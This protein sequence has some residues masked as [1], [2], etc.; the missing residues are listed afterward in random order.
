MLLNSLYF[1]VIFNVNLIPM[2]P[3]YQC[4]ANGW[5]VSV[6]INNSMNYLTFQSV[7][8]P[9]P[10]LENG[11]C[12]Q[13]RLVLSIHLTEGILLLN[14]TRWTS[15]ARKNARF[16]FACTGKYLQVRNKKTIF[17]YKQTNK[18][19]TVQ[20]FSV[21]HVQYCNCP[22]CSFTIGFPQSGE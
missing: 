6:Q 10:A 19:L 21:F 5:H 20:Y 14:F 9:S 11:E 22:S 15:I 18:K 4:T 1:C 13:E 2:D 3:T 8:S 17:Q 12:S 16:S 7:T